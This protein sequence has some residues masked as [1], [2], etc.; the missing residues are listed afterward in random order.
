MPRFTLYA[1]YHYAV[2]D[3]EADSWDAAYQLLTSCLVDPMR[4]STQM[5]EVNYDVEMTED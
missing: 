4:E 3:V 1:S 2:E 5:P